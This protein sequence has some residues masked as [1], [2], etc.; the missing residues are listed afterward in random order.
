VRGRRWRA[1]GQGGG[2]GHQV[3]FESWISFFRFEIV[4]VLLDGSF[5]ALYCCTGVR[6]SHAHVPSR[7]SSYS[8]AKSRK[9]C[10]REIP[11]TRCRGVSS[12]NTAVS[13]SVL[14]EA[15][16]RQM[17]IRCVRR[18]EEEEFR[19]EVRLE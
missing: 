19:P 1:F 14:Q 5:V 17:Q 18:R 11:Q 6:A 12:S 7:N 4:I 13:P 8:S 10:A 9:I 3:R 15:E 16:L 2:D